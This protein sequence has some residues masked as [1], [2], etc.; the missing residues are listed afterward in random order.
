MMITANSEMEINLLALR[1]RRV[2]GERM[3]F[4]DV[5]TFEGQPSEPITLHKYA[6]ANNDP[7]LFTDPSGHMGLVERIVVAGALALSLT[8]GVLFTLPF[9][10]ALFQGP[11]HHVSTGI[12]GST[13]DAQMNSLIADVRA[14][15]SVASPQQRARARNSFGFTASVN[16]LSSWDV[17]ELYHSGFNN[18]SSSLVNAAMATSG[19]VHP[20]LF[21]SAGSLPG[22]VTWHGRVYDSDDVN[23]YYFGVLV[24]ALDDADGTNTFSSNQSKIILYRGVF[25]QGDKLMSRQAM[26][27]DGYNG[28]SPREDTS[29]GKAT[30]SGMSY[31]GALTWLIKD[32]DGVVFPNSGK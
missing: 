19:E 24:R 8:I 20:D 13:I 21:A 3:V 14:Q 6:Y 28:R 5:D 15:I 1:R 17:Q 9:A 32:T 18:P 26:F 10:R 7:I 30:P 16:A 2:A 31:S 11:Q 12:G 27:A 22:T 25:A 4:T 23:Y 29:V